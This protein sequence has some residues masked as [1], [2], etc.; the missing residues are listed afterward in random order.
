MIAKR[1]VAALGLAILILAVAAGLRYA[2][3]VGILG[4]TEAKRAM[5]VLIGLSLAAYANNMP[6]QL[7]RA[8]ASPLAAARIQAALRIGGWSF[9]LAGLAYALLWGIAPLGVADPASMSMVIAAM[10][11]TLG[12]ALRAG[13]ACQDSG[14]TAP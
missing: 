5:Q 9:T 6:K 11:V 3:G 12:Y 4:G 2:Q 7:G 8:G 1:L 14:R 13:A 10:A